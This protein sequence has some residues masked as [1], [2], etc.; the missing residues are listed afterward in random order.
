MIVNRDDGF[1][2]ARARRVSVIGAGYVGLPTAAALAHF[3]HEVAVFDRDR[4]VMS[5]I[6]AG[7]SPIVEPGLATLVRE[8]IASGRLS[9]SDS[10]ERAVDGSDFVFVCVATPPK[11][12]GS[13]DMTFFENAVTQIRP[14]LAMGATIVNKSTVAVGTAVLVERLIGRT[15]VAVVS[16]PE[17]LREGS[18]VRDSLAPNRIVVGSRIR[19][20]AWKVAELFAATNAPVVVTDSTT[21]ELIKY[22]ANAFLATK[23]SFINTIA[24]LCDELGLDV[25]SVIEGVGRDP[26]IGFEFLRPGPGWGGSCLPKDAAALV[27]LANSVGVKAAI[28]QAA[29][30]A[31]SDRMSH[32]V[33]RI[34]AGAGGDLRGKT[35]GVLG[36]TFK[37]LTDDR[38]NSPALAITRELASAGAIV[39]AYDP[40]VTVENAAPDL[41]H[42]TICA[43]AYD[44]LDQAEVIAVLTEWPVFESLDFSRIRAHVRG[45]VIVDPRHHLNSAQLGELGFIT[46]TDSR[47]DTSVSSAQLGDGDR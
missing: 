37:A 36:L 20:V 24:S 43:D 41:A 47:M 2:D 29:I 40:T 23:L 17:F 19:D 7:Q 10:L 42:L 5:A 45:P 12:D 3:G 15:D 1:T 26:R 35:V 44:A 46:D 16:N 32:V 31:N 18:A 8:G 27:A 25:D 28:V 13:V 14:F 38:R 30:G 4:T 34:R 21:A 22:A 11:A 33:H 39:R 6:R 9:P